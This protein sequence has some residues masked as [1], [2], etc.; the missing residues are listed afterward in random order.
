ME[1]KITSTEPEREAVV[2][3]IGMLNEV[4]HIKSM[5]HTVIAE[6]AGIKATKVRI[7][8][9]DLIADKSIDQHQVSENKKLQRYYYVIT[10][11]GLRYLETGTIYKGLQ[12]V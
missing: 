6:T 3:A 12:T 5:S 4:R 11:K 2:R 7:V 1:I 9:A 8:L 10:D